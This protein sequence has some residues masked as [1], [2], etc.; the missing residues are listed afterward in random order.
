MQPVYGGSGI[1]MKKNPLKKKKYLILLTLTPLI[2]VLDQITKIG[3]LY[4]YYY[5]QSTPVISGFFSLTHVHNTGA[6]FGMMADAHPAFRVPFF[7]IV[8]LVALLVIGYIF[9]RLPDKS[10]LLSC[11][12]S[13]VI[14]GAMGNLL[15]RARLGFVVDF[16]DFYW[17]HY[18]FPA[19]NVADSAICVGVGVLMLDLFT[20]NELEKGRQRT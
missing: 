9:K 12:L 1:V 18:H 13:L 2:I 16:L 17:Q 19:F 11:A 20:T 7:L 8:P 3:I 5:G 10:V 15:D 14:G 4:H 6:A